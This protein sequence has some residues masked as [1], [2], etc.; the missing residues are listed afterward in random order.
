MVSSLPSSTQLMDAYFERRP[1]LVRF[2]A[3][4]LG[5]VA[6]AED[7]T[8]DLYLKIS[9]YDQGAEVDRPM[10]LLYRIAA[11]LMLD[12]LRHERRSILRDEEWRRILRTRLG[13]EDVDEAPAADDALGARQRLTQLMCALEALPPRMREAFTLHKLEGHS[14]AETARAMNIS[15]SAVEKHISGAMRHLL[16]WGS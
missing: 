15:I 1:N 10:A 14:H 7:L 8:Q 6:S 5:S 3:A 2:F 9:A 4:R 16:H 13:E 11:N 12:R